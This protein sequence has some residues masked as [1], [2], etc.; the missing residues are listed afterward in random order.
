MLRVGTSGWQYRSWRGRF[1]PKRVVAARWLEHYAERFA[2]VEVNNT[3][4]R[5]PPRATFESWRARVPDDFA[6]AVKASRY[7]THYRRMR[8]PAEPVDR[9]LD[10][11]TGLGRALGPVLLQL[12]PDFP[13]AIDRLEQT[14]ETFAGRARVAVE[15]RHASWFVDEVREVLAAYDAA[16]VLADR[17]GRPLTPM[18]RTADWCYV[19]FHAGTASPRPCYGK[20]AL[21]S[22]SRRI[23]DL[24]PG[25][26]DGYAYF[27]NDTEGCAVRDAIVFA[28]LAAGPGAVV[29]RVPDIAEAPVGQIG[30]SRTTSS[31]GLSVR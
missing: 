27:N 17:D 24:W 4:Y 23:R 21:D 18:W 14:L 1:Y 30:I 28:H 29:T 6:V 22:W 10:H 16:L 8:E 11:A 20:R 9:L 15:F 3:F 19:R 31:G 12:P 13:I 2:T 25:D 7:L 5:L 26:V